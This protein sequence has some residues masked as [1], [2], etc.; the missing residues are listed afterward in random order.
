MSA[1][2]Q[3]DEDRS[4][5][6]SGFHLQGPD[7]DVPFS[8]LRVP[9][10]EGGGDRDRSV[11][12]EIVQGLGGPA[13]ARGH[14]NEQHART[15]PSQRSHSGLPG[16][17]GPVDLGVPPVPA[18]IR[19]D[20][21]VHGV[22]DH[23]GGFQPRRPGRQHGDHHQRCG[24]QFG[25]IAQAQRIV[26]HRNALGRLMP[27]VRYA[28][29]VER[30]GGVIEQQARGGHLRPD[31]ELSLAVFRH[32]LSTRRRVPRLRRTRSGV[33]RYR[34]RFRE[35]CPDV[36]ARAWAVP[37]SDSG[38]RARRAATL[39]GRLL[40][41]GPLQLRRSVNPGVRGQVRSRGRRIA[42]VRRLSGAARSRRW[43]S[44]ST[45]RGA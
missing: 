4:S 22:R 34:T 26:R 9:G 29:Q 37:S 36:E 32:A 43:P 30:G 28:V 6:L 20:Q 7:S 40:A 25:A 44:P 38:V 39:P 8:D 11:P 41:S 35:P 10:H 24:E 27:S 2:A 17:P 45:D 42:V 23:L 5:P 18:C 16:G 15:V 33:T 21:V 19:I 1:T 3:P 14:L 12:Q 13:P 31:L